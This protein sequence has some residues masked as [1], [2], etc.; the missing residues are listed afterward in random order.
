MLGSCGA[1]APGRV[2]STRSVEGCSGTGGPKRTAR[3]KRTPR[4]TS[5]LPSDSPAKRPLSV[6]T[7]IAVIVLVMVPQ[8]AANVAAAPGSARR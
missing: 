1:W 2:A 4:S 8:R 5:T 3:A 7:V 6:V